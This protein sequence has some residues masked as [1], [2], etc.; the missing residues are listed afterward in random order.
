MKGATLLI[1]ALVAL[2]ATGVRESSCAKHAEVVQ[3]VEVID[4][5]DVL[6]PSEKYDGEVSV[7]GNFD[8]LNDLSDEA[9][10]ELEETLLDEEQ[11]YGMCQTWFFVH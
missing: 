2:L 11:L 9:I 4:L 3:S 10:R 7:V 8:L 1:V 5:S 6:D